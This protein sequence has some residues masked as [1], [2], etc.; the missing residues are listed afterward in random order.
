M[1]ESMLVQKATLLLFV[2]VTVMTVLVV[3]GSISM[4]VTPG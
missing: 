3:V 2:L 4:L 1:T